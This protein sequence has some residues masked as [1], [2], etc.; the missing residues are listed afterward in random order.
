MNINA[1]LILQSIAMMIF[2]WF[3]MKFIWPPLLK[4][5][6]ERRERVA[7]GLAA[8]DLAEKELEAAKATAGEQISEAR[9]KAGEILDQA[10]QRH[11]QILEQAK[12]DATGERQRQVAAAEAEIALSAN[13]AREELRASVASLAVIGASKIL[14][15]EVDEEA[16]RELLDKLIAE[17]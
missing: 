11:S 13:Q 17:I 1:T 15:K 8:S 7:E 14:E 9:D 2:V 12:E 4:A 16:H 10:S 5:M 3:C 6:D